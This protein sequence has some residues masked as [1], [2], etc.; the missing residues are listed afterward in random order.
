MA[1]CSDKVMLTD[2]ADSNSSVIHIRAFQYVTT[3]HGRWANMG[4]LSPLI[5]QSTTAFGHHTHTPTRTLCVSGP[6]FVRGLSHILSYEP[7]TL[8]PFHGLHLVRGI[9]YIPSYMGCISWAD[10]PT[11]EYHMS[12]SVALH[13]ISPPHVVCSPLVCNSECM[14]VN[15]GQNKQK[16]P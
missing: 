11:Y 12:D 6:H 8:R 14:R 13:S 2:C 15:R 4:K 1:I 5:W 10:D 7:S 9:S 3:S 16:R